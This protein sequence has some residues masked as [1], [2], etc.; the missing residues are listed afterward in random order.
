[1]HI[2]TRT[3]LI[4]PCLVQENRRGRNINIEHSLGWAFQLSLTMSKY[5]F[6][7]S[8]RSFTM[9]INQGYLPCVPRL[10]LRSHVT[11]MEDG[12]YLHLKPS[13]P[14]AIIALYLG[15]PPRVYSLSLSSLIDLLS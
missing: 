11:R 8:D 7:S 12:E 3:P 10:R 1:M 15:Y 14:S 5:E 9:S 6:D 4:P 2:Y 13:S